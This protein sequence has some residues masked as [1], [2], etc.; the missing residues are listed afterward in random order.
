MHH[1]IAL[2][3]PLA[4]TVG[5]HATAAGQSLETY[6]ASRTYTGEERLAVEIEY[7]AGEL[8]LGPAPAGTLYRA[9]VEFD[10][11]RMR[12]VID[13]ADRK[14]R[15]G[16]ASESNARG[17]G[18]NRGH[19]DVTLSPDALLDVSL[20]FGA[21]KAEIE[22]GGLRV[23]RLE[24]ATGASE[25]AVRF[26]EPNQTRASL[27]R[28]GVGAAALRMSDIGNVN[29]ERLQVDGG[30]GDVHLDFGGEWRGNLEAELR[31]GVGSLT[32]VLPR[33]VG[34]RIVRET[35]LAS[36]DTQGLEERSDGYY[37]NNWAQA[38]HQLTIHVGA[39]FGVIHVR[40]AEGA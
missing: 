25:T 27:V 4:L 24:I 13:Y 39:A 40:W 10:A 5:A 36:F 6:T 23:E 11:R 17:R 9:L 22:L 32:L 2:A 33:E 31:M 20:E 16:L 21:V 14:L 12:P 7:A 18:P 1:R 19:M 15:L 38:A 8:R 34:V 35:F 29:A 28:V 30:V 26:S 3:I 37:S